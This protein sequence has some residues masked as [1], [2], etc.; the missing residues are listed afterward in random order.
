MTVLRYPPT[1]NGIQKSLE[2]QLDSGT[3]SSMTLNNTT[4]VQNEPGVVVINRISSDG[5]EL[6]AASRE[7]IGYTGV[8][9]STLTGLTR[10][11]DS[12]TSDQDHAVGS[13]V[14]FIP[15]VTWAQALVD[16]AAKV[17]DPDDISVFQDLT[18]GVTAATTSAA[19]KVE[20]ATAA[21]T[22]TGT[23]ATRAVSP[24]GLAG[25]AYG[26]QVVGLLV[27]DDSTDVAVGDGA[28]DIFF[29]I[30]SR[31]N[32]W[33]LVEVAAQVQTAGTTG[34]TD[35]QIHNVTQAADM[36]TTKI[37]IDSGETDSSTAA[38]AAVIDTAND[39]VATGDSIRIDVDAVS[40]TAPK[41]L[42]VELNFQL[43]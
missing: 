12:G 6:D 43:P 34:T 17:V 30:P 27:F 19:G 25:S 11:I 42:Y 31:L 10:N 36:L 14:E 26:K 23:D 20:I 16:V 39:D 33:N 29:R 41:G 28:G 38:T 1:I 22:T 4:G 24:D 9:G 7:F 18:A 13:V 8:S 2:S 21:E 15:D 40:S 35:V 3:T 32:G 5:T 37:T